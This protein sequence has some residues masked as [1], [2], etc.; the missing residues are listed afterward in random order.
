LVG[1]GAQQASEQRHEQRRADAFVGH[2]TH[3]QPHPFPT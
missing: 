1:K 2:I 3:H